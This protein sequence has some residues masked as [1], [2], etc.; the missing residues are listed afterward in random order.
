[1][2]T[3]LAKSSFSICA[4]DD[5][6]L[7]ELLFNDYKGTI[8]SCRILSFYNAYDED[9]SISSEGI[10]GFATAEIIEVYFGKVDTN[11]V[12]L[13]TGSY[14]TVGASYLIFTY[15]NGHVFSFGG[16]CDNWSTEINNSP[17]ILNELDIIKQFS[18]IYKKYLSGKFTFRNS[19]DI[20]VAEGKYKKGKAIKLWRHYY[21]SGII[22][23]E[24]DL[25]KNIVLQ[26]YSN[27]FIKTKEIS[28]KK[29]LIFESYCVLLKGE[30][31]LKIIEIKDKSGKVISSINWNCIHAH[32]PNGKLKYTGQLEN[33]KCVG[34]WKWFNENGE[35]TDE[36]NSEDGTYK[37]FFK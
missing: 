31:V 36:Y 11:I 32:Y 15:G 23:A 1:L 24:F 25:S 29:S 37:Q 14:L 21:D 10:V 19:K 30:M 35:L 13:N 5:R 6:T 18:N 34:V 8:F 4:L 26:Y 7:T 16:N 20:I 17:K 12:K 27:G 22:K 33:G 3:V 28:N 9:Y 2:F